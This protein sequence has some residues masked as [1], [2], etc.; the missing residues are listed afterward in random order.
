MANKS[1]KRQKKLADQKKK[2]AQRLH[3]RNAEI[4]NLNKHTEPDLEREAARDRIR[5]TY[6]EDGMSEKQIKRMLP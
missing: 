3:H 6:R 1:K 5:K 2:Q 4:N